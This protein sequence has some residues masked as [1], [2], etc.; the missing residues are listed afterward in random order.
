MN[1][2]GFLCVS[3][4]S[5]TVQLH[6][7]IGSRRACECSEAGFSSQN[8]DRALG[9]YYRRAEFCCASSVGK[10]ARDIHKEM[11]PF[12][13]GKRLSPEAVHNWVANVSLMTKR[14][15]RRCG[16]G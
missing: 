5:S 10:I 11:F 4:G 16:S 3:P 12:Y 14:L 1:V 7:S 6:E 2:I 9:V 15:K 13:A 8:G